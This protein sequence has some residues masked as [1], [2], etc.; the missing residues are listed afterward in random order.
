MRQHRQRGVGPEIRNTAMDDGVGIGIIGIDAECLRQPCAVT[1]LDRREAKAPIDIALCNEAD[2]A[3]AEHADAIVEDYVVIRPWLHD[4]RSP[5]CPSLRGANGSRECA[6][7]DRLRDEAMHSFDS[8][9][10]CFATLAMTILSRTGH[11]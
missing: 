5:C 7:D 10:D 11:P 8:L 6:P 3:R 1:G 4:N 9:M 2:P